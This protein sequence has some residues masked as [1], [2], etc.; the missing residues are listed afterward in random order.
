MFYSAANWGIA[1]NGSL[2]ANVSDIV[3][4]RQ[5]SKFFLSCCGP[6]LQLARAALPLEQACLCASYGIATHYPCCCQPEATVLCIQ[7]TEGSFVPPGLSAVINES[8]SC[9]PPPPPPQVAAMRSSVEAAVRAGYIV[10]ARADADTWEARFNYTGRR[11]AALASRAQLVATDY[12]DP[13]Q[14]FPSTYQVSPP[15]LVSLGLPGEG[16]ADG[17]EAYASAAQP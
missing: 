3:S 15:G 6:R 11:D 8:I 10:R 17:V 1:V 7:Q 5:A 4:E 14:F 13:S 9:P 2:P 12:I 16:A